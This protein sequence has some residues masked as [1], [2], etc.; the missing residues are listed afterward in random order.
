MRWSSFVGVLLVG[1]G[2][3][4]APDGG[5]PSAGGSTAGGSTAGGS[6]AGGSTAGGST[7]GGSTAGGSMAGGS[8]AGGSTAGGSTAGGSMAG[9][10]PGLIPAYLMGMNPYD[11]RA[12]TGPY[13]PSSNGETM[14]D[15]TPMEWLTSDRGTIGLRG[16][17]DA[18]SG[19]G[20]GVG[21]Q[22]YLTGGGHNDSANNGL[23]TYDFAGSSRPTGWRPTVISP[24][25][26]VRVNP[27]SYTDGLPTSVHSYDG[28][29]HATHNNH[30]YRFLGS[31]YNPVGSATSATWKFELA[32]QRWTQLTNY[33]GT[34]GGAA[35]TFYDAATGKIF[36]TGS[37]T[38]EGYFFRTANDSWSAA[39]SYSVP[40]GFTYGTAAWDP[41]RNRGIVVGDGN[42][43]LLSINFAAETVS[44][45]TVTAS[46]ATAIVGASAA[47]VFYDPDKDV[48]WLFGGS[49]GDPGYTT[50]YQM[51]AGTFAITAHPLSQP[52]NGGL[53]SDNQGTYG[54]FVFLRAWRAIGLVTRHD[55]AP[56]VIKLP[57]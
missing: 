46:G 11:V 33:P 13:A 18:W 25:S 10:S 5:S 34:H 52:M 6:T 12:L 53:P 32:T 23:Y 22:L 21:T 15:V 17:I 30:L 47:S 41:T 42:T 44:G 40:N 55:R 24:L 38:L 49:A 50:L 9:G 35:V 48:Y 37:I 3:Q 57:N 2:A 56:W 27:V 16:V 26:A 31:Y 19:G 29:V 51:N 14:A 36:V 54:R 39:K 28:V 7:A 20:K 43:E 45:Q 1:C 8:T 4:V